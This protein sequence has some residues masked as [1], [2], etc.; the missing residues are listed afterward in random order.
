MQGLF[1]VSENLPKRK[2]TPSFLNASQ[3]NPHRNFIGTFRKLAQTTS[4][5]APPLRAA[6]EMPHWAFLQACQSRVWKQRVIRPDEVAVWVCP[7]PMKLQ[8]GCAL[9]LRTEL[10]RPGEVA[11][12]VCPIPA[13]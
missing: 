12:W 3:A 1:H 2:D 10:I 7:A 9:Y 5:Q 8:C 13:H 11:M 6:K 4:Q